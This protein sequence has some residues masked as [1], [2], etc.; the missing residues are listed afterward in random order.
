[1]LQSHPPK[2]TGHE[3]FAFRHAWL[4]KGV[5]SLAA[6]PVDAFSRDEAMVDL[7]VGKNMVR[8]IRHWCLATQMVEEGDYLPGTRSKTLAPTLIGQSLFGKPAWD[9]Y[10]EDDGSL[11]LIHW[12]LATNP[13]RATTWYWAYNLLREQEFSR[14]SLLAGLLRLVET[15]EWKR[16]SASSLKDDVSCFIRTYVAVKRG[17]ASTIEETL[18]C[19]LTSLNLI[20]EVDGTDR[21]RFNNGPKPGLPAAIFAYALIDAWDRHH[22]GQETLSLREIL[23]GEGSPGRVFRLDDDAV[24]AYLDQVHEVTRGRLRFSDTAMIRQVVRLEPIRPKEV[25]DA[26]YQ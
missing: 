25:L 23:H 21:Y 10:L 19:P 8:S 9:P 16:I 1:M 15:S 2:F 24:L 12:Q 14:D 3:T 4:K 6:H 18:A 7:G 13:S 11:W 20:A 17:P 22:P 5:D 26:Y